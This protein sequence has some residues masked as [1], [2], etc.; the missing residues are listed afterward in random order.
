[1]EKS[2]I[3]IDLKSFYASVECIERGL[4]PFTTNLVVADASRTDKTICLAVSPALKSFGVPGR[5]RLFEVRQKVKQVN[6]ERKFSAPKGQFDGASFDVVEL[7]NP[8]KSL[9]FLIAVPR[10]ALYMQ[11]STKIYDIYLKYVSAEDIFAYSID[12]VFIDATGYLKSYG[13]S[14]RQLAEKMVEEVYTATGI[15]ATVGIGT[16]LYLSKVAMD[17]FAKKIPVGANGARIAELDEITYRKELW[18]HRPLT[19]FWRVGIGYRKK[20]ESHGM[21]TMGDVARCSIGKPNEAWN[22]DLLFRLFG[23]NAELLIDHAWGYEPTTLADVKAY[24]PESNSISTGQV[25]HCPYD[26]EKTRLI[27]SEMAEDLVL[28][29]VGKGVMTNQIVLTVGYD[30][31]NLT[32]GRESEYDGEVVIDRYGRK[33]PKHAHGTFNLKGYSSSTAEI[34]SA[35]LELF[36]KIIDK[37]LLCRRVYVVANNVLSEKDAPKGRK[38]EQLSFFTEPDENEMTDEQREKERRAQKAVL[39]IGKK[40]GKNSILKGKNFEEGGTARDR[41]GQIGGHKA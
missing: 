7:K 1:M 34:V 6:A 28:D 37:R 21:F 39:E 29:L 19:D 16:N 40:Y 38:P 18:S 33:T 32:D 10:M 4:N 23:V 27:V 26:Y 31:E 13:L 20:L 22:E 41:N 17:V 14:A 35:T 36:E 15:T 12:E 3:A 8:K 2:Y 5:P 9:D 30:V 24:R 25:L 11:Y